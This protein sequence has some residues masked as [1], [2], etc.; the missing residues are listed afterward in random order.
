MSNGLGRGSTWNPLQRRYASDSHG[1]FSHYAPSSPRFSRFCFRTLC[2]CPLVRLCTVVSQVVRGGTLGGAIISDKLA[3]GLSITV[4]MRFSSKARFHQT[5]PLMVLFVG[6]I[7]PE[8]FPQRC[9]HSVVVHVHPG[10]PR[11]FPSLKRFA[12]P[13]CCFGV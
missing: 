4:G 2:A 13:S 7:P 10:V 6:W 8:Q 3:L 12:Q 5:Q 9:S 11:A 1:K